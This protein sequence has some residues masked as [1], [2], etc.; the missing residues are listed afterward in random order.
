MPYFWSDLADWVSME[1]VGPA[2]EWDEVWMRGSIEEGKFTAFYI[3]DGR[4]AAALTVGRSDDLAVAARL[5]KERTDIG[6]AARAHRG[7]RTPTSPSSAS[8]PDGRSA[9]I[10]LEKSKPGV[11]PALDRVDAPAAR[12]DAEAVAWGA[13]VGQ[14]APAPR[15]RVVHPR[16]RRSSRRPPRRRRRRRGRPTA[17]APMPPRGLRHVGQRS[18]RLRRGR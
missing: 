8:V 17:A 11:G 10:A 12:H 4:L 18:Q 7:R 15:C 16:P 3:K 1:Y 2:S 6:D 5:L 9:S 13:H 14:P